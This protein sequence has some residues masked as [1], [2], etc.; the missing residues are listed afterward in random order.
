MR[1]EA[2]GVQAKELD[3]NFAIIGTAD[4]GKVQMRHAWSHLAGGWNPGQVSSTTGSLILVPPRPKEGGVLY[5]SWWKGFC[6]Q[7]ILIMVPRVGDGTHS[8][9]TFVIYMW[10]LRNINNYTYNGGWMGGGPEFGIQ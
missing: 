3:S 10:L 6:Y 2:S 4:L 9:Q 1:P 5:L 7:K 8:F